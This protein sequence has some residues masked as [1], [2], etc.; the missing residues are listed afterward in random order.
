[1]QK[2]LLAATAFVL[3]VASSAEAQSYGDY[4][5][6]A[7]FLLGMYLRAGT[8]CNNKIFV[9]YG[10]SLVGSKEFRTFSAAYPET[11]EKWMR[12]GGENFN[13]GVMNDGILAACKF[14]MARMKRG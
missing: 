14:M 4:Y 3:A 5:R 12:E 10:F 6:S 11:S 7:Y 9:D 8:V 1:M 2:S 13:R